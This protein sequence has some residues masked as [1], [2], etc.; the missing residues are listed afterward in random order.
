MGPLKTST[1]SNFTPPQPLEWSLSDQGKNEGCSTR[2]GGEFAPR[3]R[4][5]IARGSSG[6]ERL[7][8]C[9]VGAAPPFDRFD[10]STSSVR[11]CSRQAPQACEDN[12]EKGATLRHSSGQ[13]IA[14]VMRTYGPSTSSWQAAGFDH[15]SSKTRKSA[16]KRIATKKRENVRKTR[17]SGRGD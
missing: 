3:P 7:G 5:G 17:G 9:G 8:G 14:K 6:T 11:R 12:C 10:G 13:A 4:L 16:T 2:R 1:F 15:E